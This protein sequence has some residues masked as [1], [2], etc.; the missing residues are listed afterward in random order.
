MPFWPRAH[1]STAKGNVPLGLTLQVIPV[2]LSAT[3]KFIITVVVLVL[4][5][6]H[7]VKTIAFDS[8]NPVKWLLLEKL[9]N[10]N[11]LGSMQNAYNH[12]PT[13]RLQRDRGLV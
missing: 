10:Y 12:F 13:S 4:L 9:L 7:P 8:S 3:P 2:C 6:G 1:Q 5:V 11:A